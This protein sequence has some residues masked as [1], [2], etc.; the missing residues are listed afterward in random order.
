MSSAST[1]YERCKTKMSGARIPI[2]QLGGRWQRSDV[3]ISKVT[4]HHGTETTGATPQNL[5]PAQYA[6]PIR[7]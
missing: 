3:H 2:S 6:V 4:E 7:S 1:Q 5:S